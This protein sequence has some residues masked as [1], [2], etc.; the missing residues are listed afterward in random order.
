MSDNLGTTTLAAFQFNFHRTAV[1]EYISASHPEIMNEEIGFSKLMQVLAG[2]SIERVEDPN[3][4]DETNHLGRFFHSLGYLR[5]S[6]RTSNQRL[7]QR[8]MGGLSKLLN[9][10]QL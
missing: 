9:P 1:T 7:C 2:E 3:S 6:V 8:S 5:A 10:R 4:T